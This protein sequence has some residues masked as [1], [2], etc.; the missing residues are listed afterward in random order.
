VTLTVT[1]LSLPLLLLL[2]SLCLF[3]LLLLGNCIVERFPEDAIVGEELPDVLG[4]SAY[5]W[6]IDPIDGTRAFVTGS[7]LWGTL[8]A[9]LDEA[10]PALGVLDQPFTEERFFA[11]QTGAY[12]ARGTGRA[13][14]VGQPIKTRHCTE[15]SRATISTTHPDLFAS[16]GDALAFREVAA[17]SLAVR[18]GGDCYAYG[19][20]AVGGLDLVIESGLKPYDIAALVPIVQGAGGV[21]TG[22][23]G[24]SAAAGGRVVAAGCPAIHEAALKVLA[25]ADDEAL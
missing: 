19:L 16:A 14:R 22:W 15:L 3:V 20:L 2:L 8:I 11:D 23:N 18:Y 10:T 13:A 9:R 17:Q 25:Q 1:L 21:I 4:T 5:T 12:F 6:V 24:Q 7:P